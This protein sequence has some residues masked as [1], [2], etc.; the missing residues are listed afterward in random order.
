[1]GSFANALFTVMLSWFRG[2]VSAVWSAFSSEQG[3]NLI[4]WIGSHWLLLA[5]LLCFIGLTADL[6]VYLFRWKPFRVWKSFFSRKKNNQSPQVETEDEGLE[7][8]RES[9]EGAYRRLFKDESLPET[10]AGKVLS[11]V[12]KTDRSGNLPLSGEDAREHDDLSR[13]MPE[14]HENEKPDAGQPE[15]KETVT[16]AGYYV[17]ADSPYRR[18]RE[19][20]NTPET[21]SGPLTESEKDPET[22]EPVPVSRGQGGLPVLPRRRRRI[23]V[24]ELF[25]DP[26]EDLQEFEAPQQLIDSRLAYHE[27]VYPR[28]WKKNEDDAQ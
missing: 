21:T 17:P 26:E 6:A 12:Q 3:G 22:A 13:W 15:V 1:M 14:N 10:S 25:S 5:V 24:A 19:R 7:S 11:T 27:P 18:P 28:G 16:S 23:H 2:I 8:K 9:G 20:L 4:Q